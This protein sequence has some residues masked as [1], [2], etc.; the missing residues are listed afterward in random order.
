[1]SITESDIQAFSD[2]A[3]AEITNGGAELSISELAAKWEAERE[4]QETLG[5][6][7]QGEGDIAAGRGKPVAE[8][9]ADIRAKLGLN[10]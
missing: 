6:I 10:Q 1:M 4:I 5:D 7:R 3:R 8:A 2:Y 9:F